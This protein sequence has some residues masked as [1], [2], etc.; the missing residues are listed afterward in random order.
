MGQGDEGAQKE[1][2]QRR[3]CVAHHRY[4]GSL[5]ERIANR[6]TTESLQMYPCCCSHGDGDKT[7]AER[8]GNLSI[9]EKKRA[10]PQELD[11]GV[12]KPPPA[13]GSSGGKAGE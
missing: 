2:G 12:L 3:S 6:K 4:A 9:K 7:K 13:S 10:V 5:L 11:F 1:E 8:R